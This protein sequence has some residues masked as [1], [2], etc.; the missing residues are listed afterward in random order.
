M[1]THSESGDAC[2]SLPCVDDREVYV[3][4]SRIRGYWWKLGPFRHASIAICPKGVSPIVYENGVPV[5]NWKRC[6]VY[7]TQTLRTGF[8]RE[9]KRFGVTA[10]RVTGVSATAIEQRM[11]SFSTLNIPLLS[12]CRHNAIRVTGLRGVLFEKRL[13]LLL[14]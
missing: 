5:S 12:D 1:D 3:L 6:A 11:Q 10:T 14:R 9:G 13:P 7:G 2:V 4:T 8:F